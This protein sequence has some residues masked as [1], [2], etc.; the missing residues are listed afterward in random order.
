M[1]YGKYSGHHRGLRPGHV[2]KG[3][4]RELGRSRCFLVKEWYEDI[5]H[6]QNPGIGKDSPRLSMS[7]Q[8][9]DTNTKDGQHKVSGA[10]SEQRTS[11]RWTSG[12]LNGSYYR[13]SGIAVWPGRWGSDAQ[14]T[15]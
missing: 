14:A 3:V 1:R 4:T 7:S 5:Q 8:S 6:K 9:E 11:L 13:W 2:L 12:S 10:D 15:H